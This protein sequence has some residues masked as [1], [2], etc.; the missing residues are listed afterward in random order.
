MRQSCLLKPFLFVFASF[1]LGLTSRTQYRIQ[2]ADHTDAGEAE[3]LDAENLAPAGTKRK[4][5][6]LEL[7]SE[8]SWEEELASI[9]DTIRHGSTSRRSKAWR[10]VHGV[11]IGFSWQGS[12][13]ENEVG[14]V[15]RDWV[16]KKSMNACFALCETMKEC[17][18]WSWHKMNQN[19]YAMSSC[20]GSI[21]RPGMVSGMKASLDGVWIYNAGER[22]DPV[23]F[24]DHISFEGFYITVEKN[25]DMVFENADGEHGQ[26]EMVTN[27]SRNTSQ[28][29]MEEW[30]V[31]LKGPGDVD[32]G[33]VRLRP[34]IGRIKCQFWL[35]ND[36]QFSEFVAEK[37]EVHFESYDRVK[38]QEDQVIPASDVW[39]PG[40]ISKGFESLSLKKG[41]CGTVDNVYHPLKTGVSFD[42]D[43]G[44]TV[45]VDD[46]LLIKSDVLKEIDEEQ[47]KGVFKN[48]AG[49]LIHAIQDP[50][51]LEVFRDPVIAADGYTYE[52]SA[53]EQMITH[54][55]ESGNAPRSPM[56]RE[57]LSSLKL[58]PN[59]AM[60]SLVSSVIEQVEV[61]RVAAGRIQ[62]RYRGHR[63]RRG[64]TRGARA[65][66]ARVS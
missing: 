15:A 66:H 63:V 58:S 33:I 2:L 18:A 7:Q 60:K 10:A 56:T 41:N 46:A 62:K 8:E 1:Q 65:K 64:Y 11:R 29:A 61:G 37:K 45:W 30:E 31:K 49:T 36:N 57:A 34:M 48:L 38:M 22:H 6:P 42:Q 20:K 50:L 39:A 14:G 53:M 3:R 19:C 5:A 40:T 24:F 12:S 54:A 9:Q 43:P 28:Q 17:I 16:Y 44:K 35:P 4:L 26:I 25:G 32:A 27:S 55:E 47:V 13:I 23:N 51:T 21:E 52:R 59:Y